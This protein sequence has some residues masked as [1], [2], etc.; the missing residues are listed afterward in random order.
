MVR[1]GLHPR[2]CC[3]RT[4]AHE[5]ITTIRLNLIALV[6]RRVLPQDDSV[7]GGGSSRSG[8]IGRSP[9]CADARIGSDSPTGSISGSISLVVTRCTAAYGVYRVVVQA[10]DRLRIPLPSGS[11]PHGA[12]YAGRERHLPLRRRDGCRRRP[13]RSR[14]CG[15]LLGV[16][17]RATPGSAGAVGF[18]A[19]A[20]AL[21]GRS[22]P[23]GVVAAGLL[24]GLRAA[25]QVMRC[26]PTSHWTSSW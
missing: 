1:C 21:V 13:R 17:T 20:L 15:S 2:V 25:G 18:D 19:I 5:V 23:A 10:D 24:R 11:T 14:R 22:H 7:A 26:A 4:G 12:R 16:L 9:Q 8:L 3:E 6:S